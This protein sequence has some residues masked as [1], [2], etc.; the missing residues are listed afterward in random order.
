MNT[1]SANENQVFIYNTCSDFKGLPFRSDWLEKKTTGILK[2]WQSKYCVLEDKVFRY[3]NK[4]DLKHPSGVF[5]FDQIQVNLFDKNDNIFILSPVECDRVFEFRTKNSEDRLNW[6]KDIQV[7]IK[8]SAGYQFSIKSLAS[9]ANFW[10]FPHISVGDFLSE[11]TTGDILLFR[12]NAFASRIQRLATR[13]Q[14]DHVALLF[15][16]SGIVGFL[17]ATKVTGVCLV[18]WDEFIERN[19]NLLFSRIVYRKL[20]VK[21]QDE[22]IFDI[23]EFIMDTQ[24]KRFNASVIKLIIKK[25]TNEDEGYFCSELVAT[26]YKKAGILPKNIYS[27]RYWPGNFADERPINL[28][29]A[30]LGPMT[31]LNFKI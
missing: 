31:E 25:E 29:N 18:L 13:G 24:G 21:N 19:W 22:A 28:I 23:K 17:E 20:T 6:V 12:G 1:F 30:S 27:S 11:V 8:E 3:F 7:H 4:R 14:Y 9:Q 26:A 16:N 10:K 2:R 5:N 15:K